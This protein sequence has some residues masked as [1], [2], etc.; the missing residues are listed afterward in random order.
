MGKEFEIV[1]E[2]TV[3]AS[4]EQV[5]DAITDHTAAWL[6]PL[7]YE[8]R[9]GGDAAFG[10]KVTA[11]DPPHHFANRVEGPDG[12]Y[13]NL[14]NVIEAREGGSWVR[15]VHSG[16]FTDDWDNQY[17]GADKHTDFYLDA[18]RR[19]VTH[20]P[21]RRATYAAADGPE[22]SKAPGSFAALV[23]ALGLPD[24]VA[25]GD[26]ARVSAPGLDDVT[27]D[28]RNEYFL[29]LRTADAMYRFFGRDAFG[30]PV[31]LTVHHFG[32]IDQKQTE[33]SWQ[34][35]LDRVYA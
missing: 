32:D 30:A 2:F 1:R 13:N 16:V 29:G 31:A 4:P 5:W 6:W 14:D 12:W 22:S 10:G 19:Y 33:Q 17:E 15:Y 35:W 21:G 25:E 11:W 24:T 9:L 8:H 34:S 7:E 27:V 26:R 18:L 23:R 3:A 28:Y 20:F